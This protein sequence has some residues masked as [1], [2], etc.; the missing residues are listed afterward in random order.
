MGWQAHKPMLNS[1]QVSISGD[2][3]YAAFASD[4]SN[5]VTGDTNG[6]RD[7]FR[8]DVTT[9]LIVRVSVSSAWVQGNAL[10]DQP[11]LSYTGQYVAFRS[12]ANNLVPGDANDPS[13]IFVR[14][15]TNSVTSLVSISSGGVQGND[16]S[17]DPSISGDG[18][19]VA[20]ASRAD[21]L[22]GRD[23]NGV[24][25][26]FAMTAVWR[27][28]VV[29]AR[30][31]T[32]DTFGNDESYTPSVNN[33]GDSIAFTSKATNLDPN[34]SD[35]NG[36]ADIFVRR[37]VTL[38]TIMVSISFFG[39]PANADSY[40]PSI[41]GDGKYI[42][43]ASDAS[44]LDLYN[45]MNGQRDIF[46]HDM[47][48]GLTRLIS[49]AFNGGQSNGRSVAPAVSDL[50]RFVAFPSRATNLVAD[51][52]NNKWD[53]FVFDGQG[54]TPTFL[55]IPSNIP[56]YPGNTVSVPINFTSQGQAVDAATF[57][58]DFD[59]TCLN[60]STTTFTLPDT[61]AGAVGYDASDT[62]GELDFVIQAA[63][64]PPEPLV[65]GQLALVQFTVKTSCQAPPDGTR[66]VNVGF[67]ED[68]PASFGASGQSVDGSTVD[69]TV[70]ILEGYL[71]D[72][73]GDT[74][75][76]AGDLSAL[77]LEIFDGD[78]NVPGDAPYGEFG[79]GTVGCN[80]NQDLQID[81]GDVSC[82]VMLLFNPSAPCGYG[83]GGLLGFTSFGRVTTD[84]ANATI[85]IAA[86]VPGPAKSQVSLPITLAS[87]GSS[88]NSLVFSVDYDRTWLSF[89]P[90]DADQ[91][92]IPV[93]SCSARR[94]WLLY[95]LDW[96]T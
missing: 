74:D 33:Y 38:N 39:E 78:G 48:T 29:S 1:W 56:A 82:E 49:R 92:G 24:S 25:D 20:F 71:G 47:N 62:D 64:Y 60:Y 55:G 26:I 54:T 35:T 52:T 65:D 6:T 3:L 75:V 95:R 43:F 2:G 41:S 69:G 5:L 44:T 88:V 7:V 10:S 37:V 58:V 4:A 16:D 96:R 15:V 87:N 45:D 17:F 36:A 84:S 30:A 89:D 86:E 21:N 14:D 12:Y 34:Y 42:A 51:D 80:P 77:V 53:V 9:G 18:R 50:G 94:L 32:D 19:V 28:A 31:G 85:S 72:C 57:S 13:D 66:S 40:T 11:S 76:D 68:P 73:N 23:N 59:E 8:Y 81:A 79:G 46:L 90:T 93:P 83:G 70:V 91:N 22:I 67:S 63:S 61:S 27:H